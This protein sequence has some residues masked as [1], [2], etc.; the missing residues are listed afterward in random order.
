M[1]LITGGCGFIGS[2][3]VDYVVDR[4]HEVVVLDK[5]T[6]AANHANLDL[7]RKSDKFF[8]YEGDIGDARLVKKILEKHS[9]R[10]LCN[11]AAESHVD[12][13]ISEPSAFIN[14]NIV[15]T[16]HLLQAVKSY[17]QERNCA[18]DFR[19]VH[20]STDE[21]FG[22]LDDTD[23]PFNEET[24]YAPNSP[25]SASKAS[26]DLLVRA[27][28][29]TYQLPAIIT[30]CSNNFGPRQHP[31]KLIPTVVRNAIQGRPIPVY[32]TGKNVRDWLY[33]KDHCAGL[34]AAAISGKV[35]SAYCF[36]GDSEKANIDV[37]AEIC[38]ILDRV[39]PSKK[40]RGCQSFFDLVSYVEDRKGHDWRYAVD[41]SKAKRELMF[42]P[43]ISFSSALE[44]TVT[45]Y[46]NEF[47]VC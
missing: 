36:G 17:L 20:I 40:P 14:T 19:F 22:C 42:S 31:E 32:G 41:F 37:V 18:N 9:I 1:W 21:V 33:V 34:Y 23:D 8:F 13:S 44:D 25:Y 35:G 4:G 11:L 6:Y 24:A 27:W 43:S 3:L 47:S 28:N 12:N 46:V 38:A 26:S 39:M 15:G 7:A 10:Y 30:N 5:M 45:S 29:K 2:H 16:Y